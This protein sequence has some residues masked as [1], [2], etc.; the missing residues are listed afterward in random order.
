MV[1]GD[2][3]EHVFWGNFCCRVCHRKYERL[4]RAMLQ[5]MVDEQSDK[6]T[7]ARLARLA[8]L[9]SRVKDHA[10]YVKNKRQEDIATLGRE[11]VREAQRQKH[12]NSASRNSEMFQQNQV[13]YQ[14]YLDKA[15]AVEEKRLVEGG[16]KKKPSHNR[17]FH[18]KKADRK[19]P[20]PSKKS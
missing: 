4:E 12:I 6:L 11:A 10:A 16:D 8:E 17:K 5:S 9:D 19:Y 7:P 1:G 18:G 14:E 2:Q 15:K 20:R 13:A 3:P